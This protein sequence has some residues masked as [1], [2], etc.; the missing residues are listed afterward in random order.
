[1]ITKT[2]NQVLVGNF[3]EFSCQMT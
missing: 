1:L 3:Y 2:S